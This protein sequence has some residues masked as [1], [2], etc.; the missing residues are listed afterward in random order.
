MKLLGIDYGTKNVGI[1]ITDDGGSMAFPKAVLANDRHFFGALTELIEGSGAE[2]IIIGE[3]HDRQGQENSIMQEIRRLA[4]TIGRKLDLPVDFEPEMYT[5]EEAKRLQGEELEKN[6]LI[7][8]SAAAIILNS[9]I[10]RD[11][12]KNI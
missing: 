6:R 8:A 2:K 9:Y 10:S 11:K 1:A 5:S 7:D 3:S 4:D 12:N